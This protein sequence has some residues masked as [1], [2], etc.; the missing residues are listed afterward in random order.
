MTRGAPRT[1]DTKERLLDAAEH[2]FARDGIHGARIREINELA[3]QRNP[4]ALHYHFG[5]RDGLV[6]AILLR[7]QSEID[8]EVE[9]CLDELE[10]EGEPDVRAIVDS[11]IRPMAAK[12]RTSSGRD[13]ARIIPQYLPALSEN[14]RRGVV[15]PATPQSHRVL[16]LLKT[17]INHLPEA[18]QRERLVDYAVVL[19]SL[20]AERAHQ[21]E[22]GRRPSLNEQ[23]F[24]T[25]LIDVLVAVMTTPTSLSG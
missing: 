20:M 6:V 15:R 18:V 10:I 25:H 16:A 14:L 23:R 13:W 1:G 21:L 9:R 17:Q 19:T 22:S 11:V 3:G 12:L 24:V 2:L 5:S 8:K 7:H 4:S